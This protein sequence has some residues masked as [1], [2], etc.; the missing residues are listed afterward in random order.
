MPPF[1]S[2]T[3]ISRA[4]STPDSTRS[5]NKLKEI[6]SNKFFKS[7]GVIANC[8][9]QRQGSRSTST[10]GASKTRFL[11]S[12]VEPWV[13]RVMWQVIVPFKTENYGSQ[14]DPSEESQIPICTLKMF[15]EE[16]IHCIEW[17]RDIF[18]KMFTL[19]PQ[20]SEESYR[21]QG[22]QGTGRPGEGNCCPD[23]QVSSR[24]L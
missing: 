2:S 10:N 4:T 5:A 3:L 18:G 13:Q 21:G 17:S 22:Y 6:Y 9:G 11:C 1:F 15:P 16:T 7:R 23:D 24:G 14:A 20:G 8:F 19:N 12:R